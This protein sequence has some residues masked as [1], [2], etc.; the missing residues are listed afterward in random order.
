MAQNWQCFRV[1]SYILD[2]SKQDLS[3][4]DAGLCAVAVAAV[5]ETEMAVVLIISL[6]IKWHALPSFSEI[7]PGKTDY[8][9]F[10]FFSPV[11]SRRNSLFLEQQGQ[12][13]L[14]NTENS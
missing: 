9:N 6:V 7:R 14:F 2:L 1:L 10:F 11:H 4:S 5:C 12:C 13:L 3:A 8:L